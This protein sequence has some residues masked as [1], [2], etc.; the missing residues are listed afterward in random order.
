MILPASQL[1]WF[2][3]AKL[4]IKT[5]PLTSTTT[6]RSNSLSSN[7]HILKNLTDLKQLLKLDQIQ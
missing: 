3:N 5:D 2:I 7:C 6:G 1:T 4:L